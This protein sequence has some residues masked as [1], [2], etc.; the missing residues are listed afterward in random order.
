M[1]ETRGRPEI[2]ALTECALHARIL[3]VTEHVLVLNLDF[4]PLNT[5]HSHRAI[6]LVTGGKAEIVANGRGYITTPSARLPKP[7][8]IRLAHQIN[9]PRPRIRLSRRS[10]FR[11]DGYRCQ[12]CGRE[13]AHLTLDHVIPRS[14]GGTHGWTN[15][16]SACAGCNRR[17]G[18]KT[19]DEAHMKLLNKPVEPHVTYGTLF[20]VYLQENQE[21]KPF[22]PA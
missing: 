5:C 2:R 15:L 22:I 16:V 1:R 13:S 6:V 17:K 10:I 8:V 18:G 19:V 3:P 9:R 21:W 12:Y 14:R 20:G 11:R 4:E 7:S